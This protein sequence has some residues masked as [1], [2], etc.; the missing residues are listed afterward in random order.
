VSR[1]DQTLGDDSSSRDCRV[2]QEKL[3]PS[4]PYGPGA[5]GWKHG[6]IEGYLDAAH[7]W[8]VSSVDGLPHYVAPANP[9][10][11]VADILLAGKS[12]E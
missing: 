9:W 2:R 3:R 8:G 1:R 7:E 10:T 5:N 11:R 12:Y 6:T 4:S